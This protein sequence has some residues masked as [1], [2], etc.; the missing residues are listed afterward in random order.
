MS[1]QVLVDLAVALEARTDDLL[2]DRWFG[3]RDT[4]VEANVQMLDSCTTQQ[5]RVIEEIVKATKIAL[6]Q[7]Y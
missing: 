7:H 5:I 3:G 1:L 6:N 2:F 4:E